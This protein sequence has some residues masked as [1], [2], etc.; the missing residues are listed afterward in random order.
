MVARLAPTSQVSASAVLLLFMVGCQ[1][2]V[3]CGD[4][5]WQAAHSKFH[6]NRPELKRVS[7]YT[8]YDNGELKI[9]VIFSGREVGHDEKWT[10]FSITSAIRTHSRN[11]SL[12]H[13]RY[14]YAQLPLACMC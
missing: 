10:V 6:E 12:K 7:S 11:L 9:T 13:C 14:N 4:F 3:H 1:H 8:I 2:F 5:Q